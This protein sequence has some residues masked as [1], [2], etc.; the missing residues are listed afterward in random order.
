MI[1]QILKAAA[2]SLGYTVERKRPITVIQPSAET[3]VEPVAE[4]PHDFTLQER[5]I[6]HSVEPYTMTSKERVVSLIRAVQYLEYY[7]IPGAFVECG[8]WRGGSMMAA[9]RTLLA[10]GST[11]RD[12]FLFDTYCGM[13]EADDSD[14]DLWGRCGT[15]LL[16]QLRKL[17]LQEQAENNIVARCPIEAVRA[18]LFS[19][20]Y[21]RDKLHFVE[22]RVESTIP[23]YA[24][25]RIGM[26]RLDTDWYESTRHELVHLFPRLSSHGVLLIDDY[27]HWRGAR[28]AV[29]EFFAQNREPIFF[30]RVD[31]T[32]RIAIRC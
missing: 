18:N 30:N 24:P 17:P 9:A 15:A 3:L 14:V 10:A 11:D 7:R 25:E 27:G 6:W 5:E 1:R 20:G 21:P 26:L 32:G 19:T 28:L 12:L 16:A 31:Y 23:R 2:D 8:V 29:D 13:P 22:G 4:F